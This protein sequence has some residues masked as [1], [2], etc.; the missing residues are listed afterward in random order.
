MEKTVELEWKSVIPPDFEGIP[1][2]AGIY[3]ISTLQKTDDKYEVK[4]VGQT[5]NLY[6]R[7]KEHWSRHEKNE[8]LKKHISEKFVMKLCFSPVESRKDREGLVLYLYHLFDPFFN[9]TSPPGETAI[10]CCLP[11]VRRHR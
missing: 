10:K 8:R 7:A 4:Y 2:K 9:N 6:V 5:D 1:D 11:M 3:I